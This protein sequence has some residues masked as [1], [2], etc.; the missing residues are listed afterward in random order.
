MSL[1]P[2]FDTTSTVSVMYGVLRLLEAQKEGKVVME[3][4]IGMKEELR[5]LPQTT[6]F[7]AE[8]EGPH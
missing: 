7:P 2:P 3:T 6:V 1:F 8:R 5:P 4:A